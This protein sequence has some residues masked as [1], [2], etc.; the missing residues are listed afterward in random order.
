MELRLVEKV[1]ENLAKI[2]H[3]LFLI[4][5]HMFSTELKQFSPLLMQLCFLAIME[6]ELMDLFDLFSVDHLSKTLYIYLTEI[7]LEVRQEM[8]PN[9]YQNQ[10]HC[11]L[12]LF[13]PELREHFLFH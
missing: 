8:Y 11:S 3:L 4:T 5:V 9:A 7:Q 10:I 2:L 1:Q 13:F 12:E 6:E